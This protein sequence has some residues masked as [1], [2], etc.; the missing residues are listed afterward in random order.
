MPRRSAVRVTF[1][2]LARSSARMYARSKLSRA[3]LRDRSRASPASGR[4]L[5]GAQRR[6][7]VVGVDP[8]AGRHDDEPLDHVPELA[9]IA[10]PVVRQEI[11]QR[12]AG[13]RLRA[14]AVIGAEM[15]DEAYTV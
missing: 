10:G 12:L 6:R 13:E 4:G 9:H 11:A 2:S 7:R 14:L 3:S 5:L 1:Q 8:V 15:R